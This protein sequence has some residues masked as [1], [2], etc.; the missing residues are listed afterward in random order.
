M[1]ELISIKV[2]HLKKQFG[3]IQALKDVSLNFEAQKMHGIIGPEAAGKTTLMRIILGLLKATEGTVQFI[4]NEKT[5]DFETLR[6]RIT[7]MPQ[8][9]SLYPDLSI[10]EHLQFFAELYQIDADTFAQRRK[11]LL[12]IT[13]LEPFVNRSAGELS[14]GMYKKLGLMCALLR[15]PEILLLDEPT[16]GVDPISRREFWDLLYRL[17]DQNLLILVTTAYMDEAERCSKVH[18]LESGH[19]IAEGEPRELMHNE[20]VSSFDDLFVKYSRKNH[21]Q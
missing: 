4:Q 19:L 21:E 7:Y 17:L 15:S 5:L 20:G 10:D 8:Q 1:T 14:G 18:L 9:Q 13:R 6:S 11:E 3:R 2:N 12:E 16:N